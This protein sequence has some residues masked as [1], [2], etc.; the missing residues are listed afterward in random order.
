MPAGQSVH[1]TAWSSLVWRP[2]TPT[3]PAGQA[4]PEQDVA[5]LQPP[6]L[7]CPGG[8]AAHVLQ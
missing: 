4:V 1:V 6:P 3:L 5:V 8:Q 7:N 2:V